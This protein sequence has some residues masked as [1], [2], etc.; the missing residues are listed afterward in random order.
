[1]WVDAGRNLSYAIKSD[2]IVNLSD[3]KVIIS[4]VKVTDAVADGIRSDLIVTQSDAKTA[5]SDG[6]LTRSDV[7]TVQS[8]NYKQHTLPTNLNIYIYVKHI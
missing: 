8:D 1:M 4:D 5:Q 6:A 7:V 3:T 2:G